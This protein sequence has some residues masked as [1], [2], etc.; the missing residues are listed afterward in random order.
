MNALFPSIEMG[1]QEFPLS[2]LSKNYSPEKINIEALDAPLSKEVAKSL[3]SSEASET[4]GVKEGGGSYKDVRKYVEVNEHENK[5]VHHMPSDWSS[6]LDRND[7]PCIEMDREDHR[8]T[9]SCGR[10]TE[11]QEYR[12]K[13]KELIDKGDFRGALQMDIDDIHEKFG[14]KYDA[15]IQEM[16]EYVDKLEQ[17]GKI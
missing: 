16:L 13:Q 1:K 7:G 12:E 2:E 11:A 4:E 5:E 9:A 17:E 3:I 8:Q 6:P 10:S 15:Q 14:D